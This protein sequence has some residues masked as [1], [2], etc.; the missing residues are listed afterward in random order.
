MFKMYIRTA[1]RSLFKD[2]LYSII[3]V[4]G[5]SVGITIALLIGLWMYDELSFDKNFNKYNQVAQV[6][7][8]VT[9]NGEVSTWK[10]MPYPLAE[11]L[12]KN[13]G[14]DFKRLAMGANW[15]NHSIGI[16][17]KQLNL[18]GAYF[19]KDMPEI[20]SFAMIQG[21]RDALS[22]PSS[23]LIS[24]AAAKACFG[25]EQP[26]GKLLQID[27]QEPLKVAG[28]YKNFPHNST[29]YNLDFIAPWEFYARMNG[30]FKETTDPWRPNFTMIF[31][32]VN[33]NADFAAISTRIKDAK[34]KKVNEQLQTKKPALFLQ[35]MSRWHLYGEFK[36]GVNTGGAIRYVTMFC[37]TGIFI[38][39][40]ACINFMNLSTARSE[41][42][43]REVG[44]RK[45]I[46]SRRSQ[47]ILQFFTSSL[48]TV[49]IAF[50]FALLLTRLVLPL[51][52]SIAEKNLQMPWN[53]G[54]F[55]LT[56]ALFIALI[57]LIAG[58][59]PAFYLSS[60]KPVKVLKGTFRSGP[61]AALPRKM[62]VVVQFSVSVSLIIGTVI[63]YKQIQYAKDRPVGYTKANLVTLFVEGSAM[64]DHFAALRA[65]L[66]NTGTVNA[67]AE[68]ESPPTG[69]WNT[70]S[71]F[72]WPGK[73]ANLST[74]FGVVTASHDYGQ[75]IGWH[76]KQ[77]RGF[78]TQF[79]TDS[80]AVVLNEAAV[81]YMNLASPLGVQ[82][83]W[84]NKPMNIIGVI[85]DMVMNSP[86]DE[87]KP[88]IYTLL[89]APG[90][91]AL[92]KLNPLI[93]PKAAFEKIAP[94]LK[95]YNPD[96][97]AAFNFVDEDYNKKFGEEQRVGKLS[98]IFTILAVFISCL[99][100]FGL[101]S[102]VAE[103]RKKEIG[104]RKVLGA[105]VF[106]V[107]KLLSK[108]FITL[109]V[110]AFLISVPVSYYFMDSWLRNYS[111]RTD[112]PWWIFILAGLGALFITLLTVSV[113]A[114][115]AAVADP[116]KSLRTE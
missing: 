57:A 3:N 58:S 84:W 49:F 83:T 91:I 88:T 111:Y 13:Y 44:I 63:V 32:E 103:Q 102:F 78:S 42:R 26:I 61:L 72:S 31:A 87:A 66:I 9:N 75:T 93:S 19:E 55:W 107:C 14:S 59:Y 1:W 48:L 37:L 27:K 22:D 12:R 5:L 53:N 74:D 90:N 105:S 95:K 7:Q 10:N 36:G 17:D 18:T 76:I 114:I 15:S 115:R 108:D 101:V 68:S 112:L 23:I 46:G 29:L 64:H 77:G 71:G 38:L 96:Q 65:D 67:I 110:I 113:Q 56:G 98:G 47:L 60:F 35:P 25:D 69:I 20:F 82:V 33:K 99:G 106:N 62:L 109:V 24:A 89:D 54:W 34:L 8:N 45:T 50:A 41:K 28:V 97:S 94:I 30:N 43:A 40:L 104:V 92:M 85:S 16:N 11:E 21:K 79:L 86:Y 39:L 4:F 100:L 80:S 73:D 70:T 2:R 6:I 51:F 52:N 81:K 116:V